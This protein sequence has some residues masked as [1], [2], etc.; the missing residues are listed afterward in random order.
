MPETLI[1][2]FSCWLNLDFIWSFFGPVC[3]IIIVSKFMGAI[4]VK[5]HVI[6]TAFCLFKKNPMYFR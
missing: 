2:C 1:M 3:V 6:K 5:E 4:T